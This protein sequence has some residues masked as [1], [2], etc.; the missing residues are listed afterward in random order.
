MGFPVGIEMEKH[1]EKA[2]KGSFQ[3]VAVGCWY[4][5]KGKSIP[6]MIKFEDSDGCLQELRNIQ[7]IKSEKKYYAGILLHRYECCSFFEGM[8]YQFLL[9]FHPDTEV[10]D[11]V[12]QSS[13][14]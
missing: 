1:Q 5:S 6:Q 3:K 8:K 13:S 12:F 10:W 2:I 9:L 4:T 14:A 11:L 7:V